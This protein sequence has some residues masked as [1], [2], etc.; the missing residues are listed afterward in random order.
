M[1]GCTQAR[2]RSSSSGFERSRCAVPPVERFSFFLLSWRRPLASSCSPSK[3]RLGA[4]FHGHPVVARGPWT[5]G[6]S[7]HRRYNL[8]GQVKFQRRYLYAP[9]NSCGCDL[10]MTQEL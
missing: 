9:P 4:P 1:G 3:E 10:F 2:T 6:L 5:V 8:A 7:V